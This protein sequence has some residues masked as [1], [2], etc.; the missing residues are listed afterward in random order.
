MQSTNVGGE[1]ELRSVLCLPNVLE[2]RRVI[3]EIRP[4]LPADSLSFR[5]A[6]L[7]LAGPALNFNVDRLAGRTQC[8]RPVVA[9]CARRLFDN[10]VWRADGPV[11]SWRS[12]DD[13]AFWNDVA[14]AEGKL[15]RRTDRFGCIEWAAAGAWRKA[16]DF[17]ASE[18]SLTVSYFAEGERPRP[19]KS[20]PEAAAPATRRTDWVPQVSELSL[21]NNKNEWIGQLGTEAMA[22]APSI[23]LSVESAAVLVGSASGSDLF[24]GAV[25]LS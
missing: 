20:Q 6:V 13:E 17:V 5:A 2:I 14:V 10:G 23:N 25:W 12:P 3:A 11:Y 7:L 24:P 16:Y 8:A 4:N 9:A 19:V 15:C 22:A 21:N 18:S 1:A